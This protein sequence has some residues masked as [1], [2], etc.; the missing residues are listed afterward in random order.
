VVRVHFYLAGACLFD[1]QV[2]CDLHAT[3]QELKTWSVL[4]HRV[5]DGGTTVLTED[6]WMQ[7]LAA[8]IA[9]ARKDT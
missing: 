4:V 5:R 6:E 9:A 8:E 2:G 1:S 7:L 3:A